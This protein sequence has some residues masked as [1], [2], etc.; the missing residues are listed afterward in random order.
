MGALVEP[1]ADRR[2]DP[3]AVHRQVAARVALYRR[4]GMGAADRVF[5]H[6]GNTLEFF[7]DLL[8]IWSLG[9]CAVPIDPRLTGFEVEA[10]AR[11]ASPRL[12]I[13]RGT[14]DRAIREGLGAL[15]VALVE[16]PGDDLAAEGTSASSSDGE[17]AARDGDALILFTSGTTGQPKGVV[18][19]HRTLLAR[20]AALRLHLGTEAFRRTLCVL[21]THFGHG[22]IC[23]AL[24]PW[25][26]GQDLYVLPPFRPDVL[27]RLGAI[28]DSCDITFL[29][30]VP[31][32]WRLVLRTARP[33]GAGCLAQVFCGSAP[34]SA[35]L[36]ASIQ[37]WAG[38]RNVWNV[39]GMTET[40]SWMAGASAAESGPEDGLVGEPW[41]GTFRIQESDASG[42]AP[43][44][45]ECAPGQPGAVWVRT[46]A[47]M[48]GYLN[49]DDLTARAVSHGW[50]ATGDVGFRD[51]RGRLHLCGRRGEEIN[52]GGMKIHPADVE[53]VVERFNHTIDACA[54]AYDDPL[55]GQD[56]GIAVVLDRD[57][58]DAR[59]ALYEWARRH[60]AQ[61][62][63]PQRWY[64]LD[65]IPRNAN[66]K[67]DR[68]A[69][70]R[71]CAGLPPADL[72][73]GGRVIPS[74]ARG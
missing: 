41:G 15:G 30:S 1:G 67:P 45:E 56:V 57:D 55:H 31:T 5:L 52:K 22:L 48:R 64:V 28:V 58:A 9:G 37:E 47:L 70:A 8:A 38:T 50:L 29:S 51:D 63:T 7:A 42:S 39:Y 14:P 19:T 6:H 24:Y 11:A 17:P 43:V 3:P 54:F 61:H 13:W 40:A 35:Q 18:H 16:S 71:R 23:N 21:P 34:L 65:E 73:G 2:W 53:A 66:G 4:L 69:V 68:A 62:R 20:W 74:R 46:P 12:S 33:P 44:A 36:W 72:R 25:L 32:M 27:M 26:A 10:L 49:A 59:R 60:L